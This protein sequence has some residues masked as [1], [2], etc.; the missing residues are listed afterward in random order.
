MRCWTTVKQR[1]QQSDY[2]GFY[3]SGPLEFVKVGFKIA[4]KAEPGH[5]K[6]KTNRPDAAI[7]DQKGIPTAGPERWQGG[8]LRGWHQPGQWPS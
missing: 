8:A 3:L 2:P 4:C 1:I 6:S 5:G 7:P